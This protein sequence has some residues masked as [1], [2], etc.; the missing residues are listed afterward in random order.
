ML[1]PA[2]FIFPLHYTNPDIPSPFIAHLALVLS[3]DQGFLYVLAGILTYQSMFRT[4]VLGGTIG[5]GLRFFAIGLM[6]LGVGFMQ[7]PILVYFK[8]EQSYYFTSGI[9]YILFSLGF[10]WMVLGLFITVARLLK[11]AKIL[12]LSVVLLT[13]LSRLFFY[14]SPYLLGGTEKNL[15]QIQATHNLNAVLFFFIAI[16]LTFSFLLQKSF[17]DSQLGKI[18]SS[19]VWG[20]VFLLIGLVCTMYANI[21]GVGQWDYRSGFF[22]VIIFLSSVAFFA[23]GLR[24][25][26]LKV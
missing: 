11:S 10:I 1:L 3:I 25:R 12:L 6:F 2:V 5:I 18:F 17:V 7:F 21:A 23:F 24:L 13:L 20:W 14:F 26:Y 4:K 15:S 19:I 16:L 8:L 22:F 9:Y